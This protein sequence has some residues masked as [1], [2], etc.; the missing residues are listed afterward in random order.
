MAFVRAN[1]VMVATAT[2]GTGTLTLGAAEDGHQTFANGGVSDGDTV[3]ILIEDG[4]AWEL[5]TGVYTATGTLLTRVLEESSTG[6]LL[7]LSGTGVTV[8]IAPSTKDFEVQPEDLTPSGTV[9]IDL[10]S[11][12][13]FFEVSPTEATTTFTFSNPRTVDRFQLAITGDDIGVPNTLSAFTYASK[14][15]SPTTATASGLQFKP[16]GTRVFFTVS[17]DKLAHMDLSTAWDI[18]TAG[19]QVVRSFP[20]NSTGTAGGFWL[21]P[22]GTSVIVADTASGDLDEYDLSTAYDADTVGF[23]PA[24]GGVSSGIGSAL[25]DVRVSSD[26]TKIY[27][28]ST[29][30]VEQ[31]TLTTPYTIGGGVTGVAADDYNLN[32]AIGSPV[33]MCFSD[34]GLV[35]WIVD[36]VDNLVYEHTLT[37][38]WDVTSGVTYTGVTA[39]FS[40]QTASPDYGGVVFGDGGNKVY[41][42]GS[43][44]LWQYDAIG[45]AAPASFVYPSGTTWPNGSVATAGDLEYPVIE[46]TTTNGGTNWFA[47]ATPPPSIGMVPIGPP[48]VAASDTAIDIELTGGYS[49]YRIV[50]EKLISSS[51][52]VFLGFRLSVDSGT[53]YVSTSGAYGYS[54]QYEGIGSTGTENYIPVGLST[55]TTANEAI[56]GQFDFFLADGSVTENMLLFTGVSLRNTDTVRGVHGAATMVNETT[57]ATHVRVFMT[58]GNIASGVFQLYGIADGV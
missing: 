30:T 7:N 50:I 49:K 20:L 22:T 21:N 3:R 53:T 56:A 1:R 31:R 10:S 11:G 44:D 5:S 19:S 33:S 34:D 29:T 36:S 57:A 15:A 52:S 28:L 8:S 14:T 41:L 32:A 54:Q 9:D 58:S 17:A 26:G 23:N 47:D 38:A 6:S 51:D 46:F 40:G 39:D 55:G 12:A 35:L 43:G 25:R 4:G 2:T 27:Y 48:V 18:S 45:A 13:T 37:T 24:H 42:S 16:D